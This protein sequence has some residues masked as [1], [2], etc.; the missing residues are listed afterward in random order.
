MAFTN[1]KVEKKSLFAIIHRDSQ[2]SL[3]ES[4][5]WVSQCEQSLAVW[6]YRYKATKIKKNGGMV[7]V[8]RTMCV[9]LFHTTGL[10]KLLSDSPIYLF[11]KKNSSIPT[12]HLISIIRIWFPRIEFR[13]ASF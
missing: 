5:T 12:F 3:A 7:N 1:L 6:F 4:I 2:A 13:N 8:G 11:L 9:N 10:P